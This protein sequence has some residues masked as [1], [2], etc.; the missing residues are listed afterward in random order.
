M[1]P[2]DPAGTRAEAVVDEWCAARL[3]SA[4][5]TAFFAARSM[6]SVRGVRL[7]DDRQVA[8]KVR[9][10]SKRVLACA[11]GHRL[12]AAAGIDCPDLLAGPEWLP[13]LGWASAEAWRPEGALRPSGDAAIA[14]ADLLRRLVGALGDLDPGEFDPPPPWAHYDHGEP[15]RVWPAATSAGWDPESPVVP[16]WVRRVAAAARE[17][18]LAEDHGAATLP[19]V[20]GHS[21]L[22]G[23]NVRWLDGPI[24]HD[25]DSL[26]ARPECV[27]AG[28]VAVNHVEGPNAGAI[29][30]VESTEACLRHYQHDRQFSAVE[31]ELAWAAG[32]WVAAYNAAFEYLHGRPG[33]VVRQ[34]KAD[35]AERL[36]RAGC[37]DCREPSH[38]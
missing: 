8:L 14:Y 32:V 3:G 5:I 10:A 7:A 23:L 11:A 27:L 28:I 36:R 24:V 9:V 2:A 29:A 33:E 38:D 16:D 35:A 13:G 25:W 1:S 6:S 26:A 37:S 18:L 20:V 22:N 31:L 4:P 15:G 19:A 17:R 21:D 12:A 30:A 34:L